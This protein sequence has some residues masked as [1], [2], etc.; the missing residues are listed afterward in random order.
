MR[1]ILHVDMN[2][3]YASVECL[4]RPEIRNVPVA[5][6]GDPENRHGII[7]AKNMLA[8]KLGV[9]TGEAIW[10][11]KLKAPGLV[12]VPPDYKKYLRFSRLARQIYYDYTDQVEA[13]GLD[14]NW[15]DIT[16]SLQCLHSDPVTIADSIRQ[17][18]KK[19]LGVTV[20]VGVS[21]NKIFAKLGSD[22]KKP[23]ATTVIPYDRFREI[24][25][26][27]PVNE[28][29][30]VGRATNR[31]LRDIAVNTIGDLARLDLAILQRKLGKW[32]EILWL[33]ANGMDTAPVRKIGESEQIKS[34]GN[35]TTCP[36][37]LKTEQDV[38]LVF[39]VLAESVAARLRDCGLKCQGVQIYLRDNDLMS[40]SRQKKLEY[41]CCTSR[42]LIDAA[43]D[44][45]RQNY[46][47]QKPL[48]GLGLSA[49][50]LVTANKHIQ[51][52]LFDDTVEQLITQEQI[53]KAVDA[54]RY[55]YGHDAILR[56]SMLLDSKLTGFNPKEDHTIHPYNYFR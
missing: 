48:R 5:V 41:P 33:F 15:C 20:S 34:I 4:Y 24:V 54:I 43:M 10:Q 16:N 7:L 37:D 31:K 32:G 28:L 56:A 13:F 19:E 47:W 29:L 46:R 2:N 12:L 42:P 11:A 26:P 25:W 49:I 38:K 45:F 22:M 55:R 27:R 23:D 51:L 21:F 9:T 3:F 6:A 39:T 18:V 14:E 17:R 36:R 35:G 8:K 40:I 53:E 30:Y 44:L 1:S 50:Y 52:S